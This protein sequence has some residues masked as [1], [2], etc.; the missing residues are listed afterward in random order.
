MIAG[1]HFCFMPSTLPTGSLWILPRLANLDSWHY[2]SA[3]ALISPGKNRRLNIKI[4][5]TASYKYVKKVLLLQ[6]LKNLC[7]LVRNKLK[8]L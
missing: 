7:R 3:G 8:K 6:L 2:F 4:G 1:L 5:K